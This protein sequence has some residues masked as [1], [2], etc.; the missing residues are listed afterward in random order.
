[1]ASSRSASP[2]DRE[3]ASDN[4]DNSQQNPRQGSGGLIGS[5][6]VN[7]AA[8]PRTPIGGES[9]VLVNVGQQKLGSLFWS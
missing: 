2:T 8:I 6:K 5:L 1:M 9:W 4:D 7:A 3:Y